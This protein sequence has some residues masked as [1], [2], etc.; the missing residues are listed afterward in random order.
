MHSMKSPS[1]L[2][3]LVGNIHPHAD[4][5]LPQGRVVQVTPAKMNLQ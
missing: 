1:M 5:T 2:T 4:E 3:D